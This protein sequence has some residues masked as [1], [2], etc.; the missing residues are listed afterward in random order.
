MDDATLIAILILIIPSVFV[1]F[2]VLIKSKEKNKRNE[3]INELYMKALEKGEKLPKD[4]L[5]SMSECKKNKNNKNNALTT[6]VIMITLSVGIA[7]TILFENPEQ[8][9]RALSGGSIPFFLGAG[10][11]INYFIQKKQGTAGNN[12]Q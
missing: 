3:L 2:L 1:I 4:I 11:I 6:G 12:E 10:F 8:T 7:L 9:G 5:T